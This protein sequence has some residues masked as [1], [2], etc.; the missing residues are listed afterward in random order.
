[1]TVALLYWTVPPA[2]ARILEFHRERGVLEIQR[3]H[4]CWRCTPSSPRCGGRARTSLPW[5]AVIGPREAG[6]VAGQRQGA[7]ARLRQ[8]AVAADGLRERHGVAVVEDEAAVVDH[9]PSRC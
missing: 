8:T 3:A 4:R 1:M 5:A 7:R 2:V 9:A 6:Q